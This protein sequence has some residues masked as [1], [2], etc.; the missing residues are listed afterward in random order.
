M[1]MKCE[2]YFGTTPWIDDR[3]NTLSTYT[4]VYFLIGNMQKGDTIKISVTLF[5]SYFYLSSFLCV[6]C[7]FLVVITHRI[8]FICMFSC[9]ISCL[10]SYKNQENISVIHCINLKI[11][12]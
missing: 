5:L 1:F 11:L 10:C 7:D 12:N 4:V 6:V 2:F 3:L 8:N 9:C